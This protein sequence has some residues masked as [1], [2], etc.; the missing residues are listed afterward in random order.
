MTR[1]AEF[2][3]V[4]PA[5]ASEMLRRMEQNGLTKVSG[6]NGVTLTPKGAKEARRLVRRMRLAE[7][8]LSYLNRRGSQ[9]TT[10]RA[11]HPGGSP[12]GKQRSGGLITRLTTR[13]QV[14]QSEGS[15]RPVSNRI[16]P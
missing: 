8:L 15:P 16:G 5:S 7:C 9:A 4:S 14:L 13:L 10:A 3:G 12:S 6:T 2:L 11:R 1:V